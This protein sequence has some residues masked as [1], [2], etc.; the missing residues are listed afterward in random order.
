MGNVVIQFSAKV[1]NIIIK[2]IIKCHKCEMNI[3]ELKIQFESHISYFEIFSI[4]MKSISFPQTFEI[5]NSVF[6]KTMKM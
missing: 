1:Q 2:S 4:S 6:F 3:Y 5:K